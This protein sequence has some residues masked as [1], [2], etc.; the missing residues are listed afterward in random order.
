MYKLFYLAVAIIT[1]NQLC[2][3]EAE[4]AQ[5]QTGATATV[6][7]SLQNAAIPDV[8][9]IEDFKSAAF[10]GNMEAVHSFLEKYPAAINARGMTDQT[11]LHRAIAG[12][13]I[14][15]APFNVVTYLLNKGADREI[16]CEIE[17]IGSMTLKEWVWFSYKFSTRHITS[18]VEELKNELKKRYEK[19]S[20]P[21]ESSGNISIENEPSLLITG[22]LLGIS[23]WVTSSLDKTPTAINM[24]G[25]Y[26]C[27]PLG[28]AINGFIADPERKREC[29]NIFVELLRRGANPKLCKVENG[30]IKSAQQ[31]IDEVALANKQPSL[32]MARNLIRVLE[33]QEPLSND[34]AGTPLKSPQVKSEGRTEGAPRRL[35]Q[36][37]V[38]T[39]PEAVN[40]NSKEIDSH[41]E[42]ARK[43]EQELAELKFE[44]QS[45]FAN[46]ELEFHNDQIKRFLASVDW[47]KKER[48]DAFLQHSAAYLNK[49]LTGH[50]QE[51]GEHAL[52]RA[53]HGY[54][55]GIDDC[56]EI[57]LMLLAAG[58]DKR[59]IA[60]RHPK[61][62]QILDGIY[63]CLRFKVDHLNKVAQGWE[64]SIR[65]L[66]SNKKDK[67]IGSDDPLVCSL[68]MGA[69]EGDIRTVNRSLNED[70]Q[71]IFEDPQRI[72]MIAKPLTLTTYMT[73]LIA[74]IKG[75]FESGC[76]VPGGVETNYDAVLHRLLTDGSD[77]SNAL[78]V[79]EQS[80]HESEAYFAGRALR[81]INQ[82]Q[83]VYPALS[84]MG[85]EIKAH[86]S[87]LCTPSHVEKA[88]GEYIQEIADRKRL[89]D[90]ERSGNQDMG[91]LSPAAGK[92]SPSISSSA[93]QDGDTDVS[94][95]Q[96][97]DAQ[98]SREK[99]KEE[100]KARGAK[101]D[102]ASNTIASG[103]S[104]KPPLIQAKQPVKPKPA[105]GSA[106]PAAKNSSLAKPAA[107]N[108]TKKQVSPAINPLILRRTA[109][110][111]EARRNAI[112]KQEEESKVEEGK[113]VAQINT[114][115][116]KLKA[117][118]KKDREG[119]LKRKK[120]EKERQDAARLENYKLK[121]NALYS[122]YAQRTK[123]AAAE[124]TALM[125]KREESFDKQAASV[126]QYV[127]FAHEAN[128][129][130]KEYGK[131]QECLWAAHKA[132]QAELDAE[133]KKEQELAHRIYAAVIASNR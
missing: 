17:K 104:A 21:N 54:L 9:A 42:R 28:E 74:T 47:G 67:L 19:L 131:R 45:K 2:A 107:K 122:Q 80:L 98:K 126:E 26:N 14:S 128:K 106:K 99:E 86:I 123:A 61:D 31:L 57:I 89:S 96:K 88:I 100:P 117:V 25:N 81:L 91:T 114:E 102:R 120:E 48:V 118:D 6:N 43:F 129:L 66:G 83:S 33:N 37:R 20:H 40:E 77:T 111:F 39:T 30:K 63:D 59:V 121:T 13:F 73:A 71:R 24:V 124:F 133:Y 35:E 79:L 97:G 23:D 65:T 4:L 55:R 109:A 49:P 112:I 119:Y 18:A 1:G 53:V 103:S 125:K 10:F 90:D 11:A 7:D 16:Y 127:A 60:P 78:Q 85:M 29:F 84:H 32:R 36:E 38:A 68:I 22:A 64:N 12:C 130:E 56:Y 101:G 94:K 82:L 87:K 3:M 113:I 62:I 95:E 27:T 115:I 108:D 110:A 51:L 72:Y 92:H 44:V 69:Y 34:T 8:S 93:N 5:V 58:L 50:D 76:I 75:Y 105:A 46:D 15:D 41:E 70:P 52:F 116:A 132:V